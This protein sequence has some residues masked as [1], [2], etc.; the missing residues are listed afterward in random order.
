MKQVK[1]F[2]PVAIII[3][4]MLL[5][6]SI[7]TVHQTE[8][9]MKLRLGKIIKDG[10]GKAIVY[11]PGMHL[12]WPILNQIKK[13]DVR[14]R[15]LAVPSSR[16]V[17][18]NQKYLLVDYY[19]KW[20]I[21]DLAKYYKSTSGNEVVTMNLLQQKINDSLRAAFG[22]HTVSEVIS[23][24]R[25]NIMVELRNDSN[26][27]AKPLGIEVVD[28][29]IKKIDLPEQVSVSV[30]ERMRAERYQVATK[31]RSD[32]KKESEK[33]MANADANVTVVLATA[34]AKAAKI[35]AEGVQQSAAIY[36]NAY[37]KN[38]GFYALYRSLLAYQ[39]SFKDTTD[40]LVL[41]PQNDFFTYL[42]NPSKTPE[43]L[44]Y[45]KKALTEKG[46]AFVKKFLGL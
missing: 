33:I 13:F 11:E 18:E 2:N 36:A 1:G 25:A 8:Q 21:T 16:L 44:A 23:G 45:C 7:F 34:S 43:G 14:L 29:R 40:V 39:H 42:D 10:Q 3:V 31:H 15:T 5:F 22:R 27:N 41:S 28:V 38:P 19:A 20:R 24:E 35:R 32:G 26:N 6:S 46:G 12:K 4:L 30:F 9:A 37:N 17:T